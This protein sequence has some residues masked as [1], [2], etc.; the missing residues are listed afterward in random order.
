M[1]SS[2]I[3]DLDAEIDLNGDLTAELDL[4]D[5]EASK[6]KNQVLNYMFGA[7]EFEPQANSHETTPMFVTPRANSRVV[8]IIS[9]QS[10]V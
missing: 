8:R 5:P 4:S 2:H 1:N 7:S 6:N 3:V 10:N 9:K